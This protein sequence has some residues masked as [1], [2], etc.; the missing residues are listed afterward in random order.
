MVLPANLSFRGAATLQPK[1]QHNSA[2]N[3]VLAE[4][5]DIRV[6]VQDLI[7]VLD[8]IDAASE[9]TDEGVRNKKLQIAHVVAQQRYEQSRPQIETRLGTIEEVLN[10]DP[11][12]N[13]RLSD[14]FERVGNKW[15]RTMA[16]WPGA[17]GTKFAEM[18]D[19]S[20]IV[21]PHLEDIIF[22]IALVTIPERLNQHLNQLHTGQTLDF[23]A[24]FE[25]ELP[26]DSTR[27]RIL[28]YLAAHPR[29]VKGI[30]DTENFTVQ[31]SAQTTRERFVGI[32]AILLAAL[33]PY[34]L[35]ILDRY[36]PTFD[37]R[38]FLEDQVGAVLDI[39]TFVLIGA[40][41]H[42]VVSLIKD[43]QARQTLV[44]GQQVDWLNTRTGAIIASI[45]A[46]WV[47]AY[48]SWRLLGPNRETAFFLGYSVDSFVDLFLGR[49]T[50]AVNQ[51]NPLLAE[52]ITGSE[53]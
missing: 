17:H 36:F 39:Y 46:L 5:R 45:V 25:D 27:S 48:G 32:F 3:R 44:L 24:E 12:V 40:V 53:K 31:R 19:K 28:R 52:R 20:R 7:E 47:V 2:L 43:R 50:T 4:A 51:T 41:A 21:R 22:L 1:Y 30:V 34:G 9:E 26:D 11:D 6:D 14:A 33:L 38:F 18:P 29:V 15:E 10:S 16:A 23:R 35:M 49:F 37:E 42:F 8:Q 13:E